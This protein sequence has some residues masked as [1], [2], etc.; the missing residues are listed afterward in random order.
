MKLLY[1][2]FL[3][4]VFGFVKLYSHYPKVNPLYDTNS[5][6]NLKDPSIVEESVGELIKDIDNEKLGGI[7]FDN[8]MKN[9]WAMHEIDDELKIT[10]ITRTTID[11]SISNILLEHANKHNVKTTILQPPNNPIGNLFGTLY[12]GLSFLI[13]PAILFSLFRT[14]TM[15]GG[16]GSP[17]N[18]MNER[19][20]QFNSIGNQD[21]KDELIKS[22]I[23]LANWAGSPEIF[24]EC[25]EVVSYLN[26]KT[27]YE[28]AGAE[29][30]KGILLEG[31]PGTGKTLIA[32]AIASECDANF[33]SV[34]A[35]EFVELFVGM[36]ASK[37]R[38][39]FKKARDNQ[40][41]IIFIDEI[42]A[43][44]KQRGTGVNVGNDEREQT[45]N[46]LLAEMDGFSTND[47]VL[48]LAATN[49]KDVLDSALLRP[50]RFDRIIQVP[51]PD[52]PSRKSILEVH[53]QNKTLS[54]DVS[55]EMFAEFT[56]GYSGA[57]LKNLL[58]EAAINA[59]RE[60]KAI[61]SNKNIKDALE[62]LTVGIIKNND[63]RTHDTIIRV[64]LHELGHA[65]LTA[66]YSDYFNLKKVSIQSTYNGA[67]GY[68]LFSEKPEIVDGGMYTK[69][70]LK[71]RI[72]IA[73][74]GKAAE[75]VFY[76]DDFVSVGASNDLMQANNLAKRMIGNYGMG[77][78]L[79]T[80]YNTDSEGKNPFLGRTL[81]SP[82]AELSDKTKEIFDKEVRDLVDECY[83]EAIRIIRI[84]KSKINVLANILYNLNIMDGDIFTEYLS[85]KPEDHALLENE[86]LREKE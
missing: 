6:I 35:S 22:N 18:S 8:T 20:N 27:Q 4:P 21:M 39:L 37:V 31:P 17:I 19:M 70:I 34:S 30:P 12:S 9:A 2:L 62:K 86:F 33:I 83:R 78:S 25:T 67:G 51:L 40:P 82:N 60:S 61:I 54:K 24:Q 32:K 48:I 43:V 58:N 38:N 84:N 73:L 42:D 5:L 29:V 85:L 14:F 72:I 68:T 11:P 65:Y 75:S 81:A 52:K 41:S 71:K 28:A 64:C 3:Q 49:R 47:N 66:T 59:A 50:G 36:G 80:Y 10:D 45:L 7:Y 53:S 74:G 46:Q 15:M 26:D 55:L 23:S 77:D 76:G 56:A 63:T 1:L 79:K 13:L 57:Q 16:A 44:G 69:D